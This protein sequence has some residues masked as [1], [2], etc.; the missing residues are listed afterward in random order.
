MYA[1]ESC[2]AI[3]RDPETYPDPEAFNP[4]RW[5]EPK[6][7]TYQEPLTQYPTIINSTQFGYGRRTCQ[8]QTVTDEDLLI[9]IGSIA[10]L[11]D[12]K[13][14]SEDAANSAVMKPVRIEH[15]IGLNE[16]ASISNEELNAGLSFEELSAQEPTMEEKI[17]A[18]F[19][20]PGSEPASNTTSAKSKPAEP[21]YKPLEWGDITKKPE[22]PTLDY[23]ILLI[24]K[25][26]P[27]KFELK[28]RNTV[29]AN[30]VR[31]LFR[32]GVESGDFPETRNY[33]G[34]NQGRDKPLG[35]SKV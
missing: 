11:F 3:S 20:Y 16:K 22:D 1:N 31:S 27:F 25:P 30:K 10:W 9:G 33:W 4:L 19:T 26:I 29:R 32:E 12:I 2:R 14:G 28:P 18:R 24:A 21:A 15:K 35:W 8:G 34:P 7:P 17:L 13:K 5:I 23:S 6:Y